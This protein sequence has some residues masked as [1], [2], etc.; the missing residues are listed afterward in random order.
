MLIIYDKI[1]SN[2]GPILRLTL[3]VLIFHLNPEACKF[4]SLSVALENTSVL[5]QYKLNALIEKNYNSMLKISF[6]VV[7]FY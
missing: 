2:Y 6:H 4:S 5:D 1:M 7:K 3:R